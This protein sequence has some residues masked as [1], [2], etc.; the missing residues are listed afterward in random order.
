[1]AVQRWECIHSVLFDSATNSTT[2]MM[3]TDDHLSTLREPTAGTEDQ[4]QLKR[5]HTFSTLM[6]GKSEQEDGKG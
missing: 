1:M 3:E 6:M 2:I 4:L 5:M